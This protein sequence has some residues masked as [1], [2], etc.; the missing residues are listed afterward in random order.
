[1]VHYVVAAVVLFVSSTLVEAHA[2]ALLVDTMP[3]AL[4]HGTLNGALLSTEEGMP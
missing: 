3:T 1:M 4:A 2:I